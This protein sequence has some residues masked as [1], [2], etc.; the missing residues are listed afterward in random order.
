MNIKYLH[1]EI[2]RRWNELDSNVHPDL[3]PAQLDHTIN[4]CVEDFIEI[5]YSGRNGKQYNL[6]FEVTQQRIDMLS[7]LVVGEPLQPPVTPKV[8]TENKLYEVPLT[9]EYLIKPYQHMVRVFIDS[10]CGYINVKPEQHD[11][12]NHVLN[13]PMR[14]PSSTWKRAVAATRASSEGDSSSLYVYTDFGV[15]EIQL[16]YI[17]QPKPAFFGGYDSYNYINGDE[18]AD[19]INTPPRT[20]D[21]PEQYHNLFV[22]MVVQELSRIYVEGDK[23]QL[24]AEKIINKI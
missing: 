19:N 1:Y 18:T 15:N 8:I 22:D 4:S 11:D 7:N 21:L 23:F 13:N 10:D 17:R 6:G 5:F 9:S 14:K 2:K 3:P 20:V 16:E 12:L 24:S